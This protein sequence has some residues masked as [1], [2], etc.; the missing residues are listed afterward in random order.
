MIEVK[1][2]HP[3]FVGEVSGVDLVHVTYTETWDWKSQ[4]FLVGQTVTMQGRILGA[5]PSE[6]GAAVAT[7]E[8]A[9]KHPLL[10]RAIR[11]I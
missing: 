6:L 10:E 2:L 5:S 9:L 8:R 1:Q 11:N 4:G 3:L 7:V